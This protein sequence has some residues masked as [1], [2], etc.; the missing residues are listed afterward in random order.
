MTS[1]DIAPYIELDLVDVDA[2]G[3]FDR[4]KAAGSARLGGQWRFTDAAPEAVL[5]EAFSITVAE[6]VYAVNR[7]PA[8][9]VEIILR[10]FGVQ[11][12]Q[13][14]PP[15]TTITFLASDTLGHEVP[16]G[17]TIRLPLGDTF[18]DFATDVPLA[19]PPGSDSGTVLAVGQASTENAN[20]VAAG[21]AVEVLDA[22]TFVDSARLAT[23][24]TGG[25][26]VESGD[27]MLRRGQA[28]LQRLVSTLVT[29]LHF[30]AAA[31]L[32]PGVMRAAAIDN[33]NVDA[34]SGQPGDHPGHITVAVGGPGGV[35]L[36]SE[37]KALLL[38][39]LDSQALALLAVH[40]TDVTVTPV[41]ITLRV[42]KYPGF[43]D[44]DVRANVQQILRDYLDTD[45]WIFGRA[46]YRNE[47]L[48]QADRADGVDLVSVVSA[49]AADVVLPGIAALAAPGVIT[50]D[51]DSPL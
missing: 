4:A 30:V 3:V 5:L 33:F 44:E 1:P 9:I 48:A 14:A 18:L 35:A 2:E 42:R 41:N 20:G 38:A 10:L 43:S 32:S 40:M 17:T 25:R 6:L 11:R 7:L 12:D 19:I 49:P 31:A 45:S 51:I 28:L 16:V 46:V 13:G 27:E 36:S 15:T 29:P 47:I 37:A 34:G 39:D 8:V 21:T 24:P 26:D 23:V 22:L 50:V